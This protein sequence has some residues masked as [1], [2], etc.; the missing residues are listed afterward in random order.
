MNNALRP[1]SPVGCVDGVQFSLSTIQSCAIYVNG[2]GE[3]LSPWRRS[4]SVQAGMLI[5]ESCTILTQPA[6]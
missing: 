3:A 5:E 2:S 4:K 6:S 1:I